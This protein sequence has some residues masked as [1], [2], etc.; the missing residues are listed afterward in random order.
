[1]SSQYSKWWWLSYFGVQHTWT[2]EERHVRI[3]LGMSALPVMLV[4]YFITDALL[5]LFGVERT[6]AALLAGLISTVLAF[7][8]ARPI[9][10]L[11]Y[12]D[13]LRKADENARKRLSGNSG[14]V[15]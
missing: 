6:G 3:A 8:S 12:P 7:F 4:L 13:S 15:R 10:T 1:M 11:L 9:A 2:V 5:E 14:E